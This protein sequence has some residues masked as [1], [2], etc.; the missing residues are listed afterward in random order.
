MDGDIL[1]PS[2][3]RPAAPP[4]PPPRRRGIPPLWLG[5]F[6]L[7]LAGLTAIFFLRGRLPAAPPPRPEPTPVPATPTPDPTARLEAETALNELIAEL[8][9]LRPNSPELW[10][11]G[12]WRKI[13]DGQQEGNTALAER[14]FGPA[15]QAYREALA[16]ARLLAADAVNAPDRLWTLAQSAYADGRAAEAAEAL[17]TL[18]FLRPGDSRAAALLPRARVADQSHAALTDARQALAVSDAPGA[19][20]AMQTLEK[21][22]ADFPGA[23]ETRAEIR[24]AL[25]ADSGHRALQA[26]RRAE[27]IRLAEELETAGDWASATEAWQRVPD[28]LPAGKLEQLRDWGGVDEQIRRAEAQARSPQA[29]QLERELTEIRLAGFPPVLATRARHFLA[30]RKQLRQPVIL[31]MVSDGETSVRIHRVR[32]FPPFGEERI[33]LPPGDYTVI[34]SRMGYRDVRTTLTL[35]PGSPEVTLD[36]RA[37]ESLNAP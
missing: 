33:A 17:E 35:E 32:D 21:L 4:S 26:E 7:L 36:I 15:L 27:Q 9:A 20:L 28:A 37:T 6:L 22:D 31:R 8:R 30:L 24:A 13:L 2:D 16:N 23:A 10:A 25:D 1:Q 3:L 5:G 11:P 34:G 18:L 14:R 19:W 12:A 29:D